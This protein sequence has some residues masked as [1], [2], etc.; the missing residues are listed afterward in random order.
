MTPFSA[1]KSIAIGLM[2]FTFTLAS[3][4]AHDTINNIHHKHSS[5]NDI[6]SNSSSHRLDLATS[7]AHTTRIYLYNLDR[8]SAK[9]SLSYVLAEHPEI[10]GIRIIETELNDV[11]FSYYR[12]TSGTH[13]NKNLPNDI[14]SFL[15]SKTPIEYK[16]EA[17]GFVE[18]YL[19]SDNIDGETVSYTKAELQYLSQEPTIIIGVEEI[20]PLLMLGKNKQ[21]SGLLVDYIEKLFQGTSIKVEYKPNTFSN[22]LLNLKAKE[23]D[24]VAGAYYHPSREILG[25]FSLPFM[26]LKDYLYTRADDTSISSIASLE[27]KSL[28]IVGSYLSIDLVKKQYPRITIHETKNLEEST[29]LV[30]SGQ[31]DALLDAQLFVSYL[32]GHQSLA[33][34]RGIPQS[35]IPPQKLHLLTNKN[36]PDLS[37]IIRKLQTKTNNINNSTIMSRFFENEK[38]FEE[39]KTTEYA[40]LLPITLLLLT[41]FFSFFLV[42]IAFQKTSNQKNIDLIFS[43]KAFERLLILTISIFSTFIIVGSWYLLKKNKE[44][45]IQQ[46]YQSALERLNS[47]EKNISDSFDFYLRIIEHEYN[48]PLLLDSIV[49]L[50]TGPKDLK[51]QANITVIKEFWRQYDYFSKKQARQLVDIDGNTLVGP[52]SFGKPNQLVKRFPIFLEFSLMG[53]IIIQPSDQ[54]PTHS[55]VFSRNCVL[56]FIPV[57]DKNNVVKAVVIDQLYQNMHFLDQIKGMGTRKNGIVYPI[58]WRGNVLLNKTEEKPVQQ[59]AFTDMNNPLLT[60]VKSTKLGERALSGHLEA[61]TNYQ[62]ENV[63]SVFSWNPKYNFGL[64][65]ETPANEALA[66]YKRFRYSIIAIILLMLTFTVPLILF[67]LKMGRRANENLK[68][69]RD[70]L[71][72]LVDLRTLE[73]SNLEES[74]RLILSSIGQGLIGTDADFNV[75]YANDSALKLLMYTEQDIIGKNFFSFLQHDQSANYEHIV[76]GLHSGT[77]YTSDD[78]TFTRHDGTVFSVECNCQS[79]VKN[80]ELEGSVIVFGDIT[81]RM[82]LQKDLTNARDIAEKASLTKGEFLAN[83]SH[84]IR[85]PMNAVIGMAYLALQTDLNPKQRNY[86]KKS[87]NAALLLLGIINDILDFSK[88]EAGKLRLE[89]T[90]FDLESTLSNIAESVGL[91]ARDKSLEFMF[92][93]SPGIPKYVIGDP[94]RLSQII[95]NLANNAVKFTHSGEV[96][97]TAKVLKIDFC[98]DR[99][100]NT[101]EE[102]LERNIKI[103]FSVKDT[104]IGLDKQHLNNLFKPFNQADSST[105][106]QY[107]GTGLG[108]VISKQLSV[109]MDGRIWAE[110]KLGEGSEFFVEVSLNISN[111]TSKISE[112]SEPHFFKHVLVVDDNENTL[113]ILSVM[114]AEIGLHVTKATNGVEAIKIFNDT[115]DKPDLILIDWKMPTL[116]G[117]ETSEQIRNACVD[118]NQA[119]PKIIITTAFSAEDAEREAEGKHPDLVQ[120]YLCKPITYTSLHTALASAENSDRDKS[121]IAIPLQSKDNDPIEKLARSLSG[122]KVLLVEDNEVNREL[123]LELLTSKGII[124]ETANNGVEAVEMVLAGNFDGVLMDCQMPIM[125]G[126]QATELLR[127]KKGYEELPIL[128]MTANALLSDVAKA[129]ASGMNEHIAKPVNITELFSKMAAW[130]KPSNTHKVDHSPSAHKLSTLVNSEECDWNFLHAIPHLYPEQGMATCQDNYSLYLRLLRKFVSAENDFQH[131]FESSLQA[132][133]FEN[134]KLMAHSLKGSAAN[135]G[136][137]NISIFAEKIEGSIN[138]EISKAANSEHLENITVQISAIKNIVDNNDSSFLPEQSFELPQ[139]MA[140]LNEMIEFLKQDDTQAQDSASKIIQYLN[141]NPETNNL[142]KK[143][144]EALDEY[145]FDT[146]LDITLN[147]RSILG[148]EHDDKK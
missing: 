75:I 129:K 104:G 123:A 61:Y 77:G 18:L 93:L 88:I 142:A 21:A 99:P 85:T 31:V 1:A 46:T 87:H 140:S 106:R 105:T 98:H 12:D 82:Q 137:L 136:A 133:N 53:E 74:S 43:S 114:C 118:H 66:P 89:S 112:S 13:F 24:V 6:E 59:R 101:Q 127:K 132:G 62:G 120:S 42:A 100:T 138:G 130:I 5:P 107:G 144:I 34:L 35:I 95:M 27:G 68:L 110:S 47:A 7:I 145:D 23:L 117:I 148:K 126:Y 4:L 41:L 124:V 103:I 81:D 19:S 121:E 108:L 147:I 2:L 52:E 134:C 79:M 56:V 102:D 14:F 109:L 71:S 26:T 65:S 69:S 48:Q 119:I 115:N 76:K 38:I 128:A 146:A 10:V 3:S 116:N 45:V 51:R 29:G 55:E 122:A 28:A 57:T 11:F 54:C 44:E 135:I 50:A 49:N 36:N 78:E 83:M 73:L 141:S 96:T 58:D 97:I 70:Q 125:D 67:T 40:E 63:L 72:K 143:A 91:N 111:D 90:A 139:V 94:L 86:I 39:E 16:G 131:R 32:Q 9:E 92:E 60:L 8:K 84:E 64:S 37:S 22:L 80:N 20:P 30:L 33:G 17:L 25:R 15:Y 113:E